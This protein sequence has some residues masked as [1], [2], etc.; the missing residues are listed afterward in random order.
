[1]SSLE[2]LDGASCQQIRN[3]Q[4]G[5]VKSPPGGGRDAQPVGNRRA[6]VVGLDNVTFL[7]EFQRGHDGGCA[8]LALESVEKSFDTLFLRAI[9]SSGHRPQ[10][11]LAT[12][13][14]VLFKK[15]I[16][17]WSRPASTLSWR[18]MRSSSLA[19]RD[20]NPGMLRGAERRPPRR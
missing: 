7:G 1:M 9:Q 11:P 14:D 5:I 13:S 10:E 8:R 15:R 19:V 2:R 12:V 4:Q 6:R 16:S 17:A 18:S 20:D 3:P